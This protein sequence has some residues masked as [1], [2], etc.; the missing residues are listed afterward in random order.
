MRAKGKD[1][2]SSSAMAT[3]TLLSKDPSVY[4]HLCQ[5]QSKG[6]RII[7]SHGYPHIITQRP[8]IYVST[9]LSEP[10]ERTHHHHHHH[11]PWLPSY[12][13]PK[14]RH[15]CI[16][17]PV[18]AKGKDSS[19]SSSSSSSLAMATNSVGKISI[20]WD[21]DNKPPRYPPHQVA[22][23]LKATATEFGP[24]VD[25]LAFANLHAFRH[26][27]RWSSLNPNFLKDPHVHTSPNLLP[28]PGFL[29][30]PDL[31]KNP[32][33]Y[34]E[35]PDQNTDFTAD[36]DS[37]TASQNSS[38]AN[39]ISSSAGP[40][41]LPELGCF[42]NL[43]ICPLCGSTFTEKSQLKRHR[44]FHHNGERGHKAATL[45]GYG[46]GLE[47]LRAGFCVKTVD[48]KSQA[49]DRA[50]K[51]QIKHSMENGLNWICIV[52]D[53]SG[54][55]EILRR[56]REKGIGI[57][58]IGD[59]PSL[60]ICSDFWFPWDDV[61][62]GKLCGSYECDSFEFGSYGDGCIVGCGSKKV[63]KLGEDKQILVTPCQTKINAAKFSNDENAVQFTKPK[64]A[65]KFSKTNK[66]RAFYD[67]SSD[68]SSEEEEEE[69]ED[70]EPE[71][72]SF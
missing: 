72:E 36:P 14:T 59:T 57:I 26:V 3:L 7:I 69:E 63:P 45:A 21:L 33:Y 56:G 1:P 52:S 40:N 8:I 24:I 16:Y 39:P 71:I 68:F 54:F 34:S 60:R 70:E 42:T 41:F 65:T 9:S 46:L 32:K 35:N 25:L 31:Q 27:P 2:S 4:L 48:T 38:C 19:S 5:S 10:R 11:Q 37:Y 12:Y 49:A 18:R 29:I 22:L 30:N 62:Q 55:S 51:K 58:S 64:S 44:R 15:L 23:N 20:F 43:L 47:L 13:L 61:A 66:Y 17:I 6:L 28:N 50:M 53:D 67:F